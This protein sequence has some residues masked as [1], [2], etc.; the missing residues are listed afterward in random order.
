MLSY[1]VK[2]DQLPLLVSVKLARVLR[3]CFQNPHPI[4]LHLAE[5]LYERHPFLILFYYTLHILNAVEKRWTWLKRLSTSSACTHM[6]AKLMGHNH[7]LLVDHNILFLIKKEKKSTSTW[8]SMAMKKNSRR[9]SWTLPRGMR[10]DQRR[11]HRART[12]KLRLVEK[13]NK[14]TRLGRRSRHLQAED[15]CKGVKDPHSSTAPT[16][17]SQAPYEYWGCRCEH[18]CHYSICTTNTHYI[19]L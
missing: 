15:M 18:S 10:R 16:P 9:H 8:L 14:Y 1:L 17:V 11:P 5:S 6:I 3:V 7:Y 13:F 2:D 19:Y 4:S 12:V